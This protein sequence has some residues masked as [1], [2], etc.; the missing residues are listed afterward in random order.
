[1]DF[2]RKFSSNMHNLQ[3]LTNT[4]MMNQPIVG[5]SKTSTPIRTRVVSTTQPNSTPICFNKLQGYENKV[6]FVNK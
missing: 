1:M 6:V 2:K 4:Q 3:T 5:I